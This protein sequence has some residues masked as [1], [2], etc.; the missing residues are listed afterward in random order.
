MKMH[1][2]LLAL[3]LACLLISLAS[4]KELQLIG[5][6]AVAIKPSIA[7]SILVKF[8]S[9]DPMED[10]RNEDWMKEEI[11]QPYITYKPPNE[12]Y[13]SWAPYAYRAFLLHFDLDLAEIANRSISSA[14]L[15]IISADGRIQGRLALLNCSLAAFSNMTKEVQKFF[16]SYSFPIQRSKASIAEE[17]D[18]PLAWKKRVELGGM[19]IEQGKAFLELRGMAD[20]INAELRRRHPWLVLAWYPIHLYNGPTRSVYGHSPIFGPASEN[21]IRLILRL[22]SIQQAQSKA[23][24]TMTIHTTMTQTQTAQP[25]MVQ[26]SQ[27]SPMDRDLF[28]VFALVLGIGSILAWPM[29]KGR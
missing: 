12:F 23:E 18:F 24:T 6:D 13:E 10:Y 17:G 3:S 1:K 25:L 8:A 26:Q 19:N 29:R 16:D 14:H 28:L 21:S 5:P 9:D 4:P 11:L 7:K 22:G 15:A 20:H 2:I 27:S